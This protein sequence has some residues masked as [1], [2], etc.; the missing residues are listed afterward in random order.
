MNVLAHLPACEQ[1]LALTKRWLKAEF[2]C[3][4]E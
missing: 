4:S 3:L 1:V 2:N